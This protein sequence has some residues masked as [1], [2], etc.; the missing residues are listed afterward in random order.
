MTDQQK[1]EALRL[2]KSG[3]TVKNIHLLIGSTKGAVERF[4]YKTMQLRSINH[5]HSVTD[6]NLIKRLRIQGKKEREILD[7]TGLKRSQLRHLLHSN[8]VGLRDFDNGLK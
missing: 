4:I 3:V 8:G 7:L 1:Q 5:S 2:Y 6:L